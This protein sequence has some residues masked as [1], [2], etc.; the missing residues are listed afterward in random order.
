MIMHCGR[1]LVLFPASLYLKT[2]QNY[3]K[4]VPGIF[5]DPVRTAQ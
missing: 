1:I 4:S 3:E 2:L 5:K